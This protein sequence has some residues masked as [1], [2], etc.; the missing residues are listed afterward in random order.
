MYWLTGT[1]SLLAAQKLYTAAGTLRA[2]RAGRYG[3]GP[4]AVIQHGRA[5]P[6]ASSQ[7][8]P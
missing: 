6:D 3:F 4:D 5:P 1:R 2:W 8:I 7:P